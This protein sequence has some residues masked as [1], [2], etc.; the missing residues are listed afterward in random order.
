M[1]EIQNWIEV[2]PEKRKKKK[3]IDENQNKKAREEINNVGNDNNKY[4]IE[5]GNKVVGNIEC[6]I[7]LIQNFFI[8]FLY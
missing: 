7:E 4:T 1:D 2:N 8:Y 3:S 6:L 5:I